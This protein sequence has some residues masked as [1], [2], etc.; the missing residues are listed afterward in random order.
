MDPD[1]TPEDC[2]LET[3]EHC[4]GRQASCRCVNCVEWAVDNLSNELGGWDDSNA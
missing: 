2:C 1:E 4:A 3:G